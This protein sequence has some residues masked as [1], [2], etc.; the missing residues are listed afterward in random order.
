MCCLLCLLFTYC[1]TTKLWMLVEI[2]F[3]FTASRG[4]D[5]DELNDS[6]FIKLDV[7]LW[8]ALNSDSVLMETVTFFNFSYAQ[9]S[10]SPPV[11]NGCYSPVVFTSH[12]ISCSAVGTKCAGVFPGTCHAS[13]AAAQIVK[14]IV[15]LFPFFMK[16]FGRVIALKSASTAWLSN[17][18]SH[19]TRVTQTWA[20]DG[21]RFYQLCFRR[22]VWDPQ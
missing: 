11:N 5:L 13:H 2:N 6:Q 3:T 14:Q 10:C 7:Q 21:E 9:A 16:Y 22:S 15:N 8:A 1:L 20:A 17:C 19:R 12:S 18:E 4:N